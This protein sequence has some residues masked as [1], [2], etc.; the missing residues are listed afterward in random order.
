MLLAA[1]KHADEESF[2][3]SRPCDI[4]KI[5]VF[6][7]IFNLYINGRTRCYVIYSEAYP[8][9]VH[10]CHRIFYLF[11]GAGPCRNVKKREG[12][13]LGLILAVECN[14]RV[15]RRHEYAAVNAKLITAYRLSE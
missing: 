3:V 5:S 15:V 12:C 9:R 7:E 2:T 11:K 14:L 13:D 10:S 8:F 4:G 1:V 6:S